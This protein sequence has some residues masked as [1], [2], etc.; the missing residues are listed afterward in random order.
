[1]LRSLSLSSRPRR[2]PRYGVYLCAVVS[3]L[4]LLLSV[5]LL[6]SRL[7]HSHSLLNHRQY[8]YHSTRYDTVSL[9]NPLIS[10]ED[11]DDNISSSTS[12]S[13]TEDKIDEL[14]DIEDTSKND[15][16]DEDD[17][18]QQPEYDEDNRRQPGVSSIFFYDH[19]TG[20][21][22][23]AFKRGSIEEWDDND[24]VGFNVGLGAL[25]RTKAAFGSDDVPVDE[26]VRIKISEVVDIEDALLLKTGRKVSPL[27]QGWGDWF[28][29]K[30]D[31]LRRDRMFKSNLEI[32]NPLNN[33]MLQDPD[34]IGVTT[35]TKGDRLVQKA[36][37][38]EFKRV[39]FLVK[40]PPSIS[41]TTRES[42]FDKNGD[43]NGFQ[44]GTE[45][46]SAIE[47]AK[48]RTLDESASGN[49]D[50]KTRSESEVTVHMYAD[51][52]RWGYYPGLDP[53]LSF[54]DFMEEFFKQGKC[55]L[56]VY[57]V[58]NSPPWMYSVRY[59][60]GLESLF[61]HHPNACVVI[62]SETIDLDFFKESFVKDGYAY[63]T[64]NFLKPVIVKSCVFFFTF[65]PLYSAVTKLLLSC[66]IL[67]NC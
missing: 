26:E 51:G 22:R 32:L 43:L 1:M 36:L 66:Q 30:G 42:K 44:R 59:Q 24:Y 3:S 58:W 17:E 46:E 62:F 11:L 31:F 49:V 63:K 45:L 6:Y 27:R 48:R 2:R 57:M 61:K 35:L 25:D 19:V 55:D 8:R 65:P 12:I 60:R 15:E 21:I 16:L 9:T 14:D 20:A 10:D 23:K 39:P 13:A 56:K 47:R 41:E 64:F 7:S 28:D 52:K 67:M 50:S 40:K 5:S 38:N 33:P 53:F 29:K 18:R 34:G 4:L 54:S 37:L